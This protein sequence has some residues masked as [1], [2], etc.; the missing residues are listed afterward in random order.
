MSAHPANPRSSLGRE[1]ILFLW[2]FAVGL[3]ILPL[4]IYLVGRFVFGEYGGTGF[5]DFYASLH[6]GLWSGEVAVWFLILSP[7]LV[8]QSL[9]LTVRAFRAGSGK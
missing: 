2:L 4:A 8:W 9:R 6:G 5:T 1:F 7:Y 3:L